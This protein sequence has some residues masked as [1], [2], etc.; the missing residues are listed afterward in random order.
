MNSI[1]KATGQTKFLKKKPVIVEIIGEIDEDMIEGVCE[2]FHKAVARGQPIIPVVIH[3]NGGNL[4]D[5][6]HMIG[7]MKTA[8]VPVATIVAGQAYSAAA[9]IFSC[10]TEGY[11][12]M[13]PNASIM[14]HDVGVEEISGKCNDIQNEAAE[15]KRN[16]SMAYGMMA[17]NTEQPPNF[18]Y[19][20][21]RA[22]HGSDLYVDAKKAKEWNLANHIG[23]PQLQTNIHVT[24][25]LAVPRVQP[26]HDPSTQ[27][28]ELTG[29]T[30]SDS[31]DD[32]S[33][34]SD[35]DGPKK[36]RKRRK[37]KKP[38][39]KDLLDQIIDGCTSD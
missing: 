12:F 10:G 14:L 1:T 3:S 39:K 23:I 26:F 5:A 27:F 11:R 7:V 37:K 28:V 30:G 21:V 15:L 34:D 33:D 17:R 22:C 18:F 13:A 20:K 36:K 29:S 35:N 4:F 19:D 25:T 31:D 2:N 8:S 32:D 38:E 24:V 16:N 9:L 6:I